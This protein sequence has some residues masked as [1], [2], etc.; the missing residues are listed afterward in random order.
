M[1]AVCVCVCVWMYAKIIDASS[2]CKIRGTNWFVTLAS[3][4]PFTSLN[5]SAYRRS[6]L[7]CFC[8]R[9]GCSRVH[10]SG[11][12]YFSSSRWGIVELKR[13]ECSARSMICSAVLTPL[14]KWMHSTIINSSRSRVNHRQ[15]ECIPLS[16]IYLFQQLNASIN[17]K[18]REMYSFWRS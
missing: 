18:M 6:S 7:F 5:F 17:R 13:Q 15:C 4:L 12:K 9:V 3:L 8:M 16:R 2:S 1:C 14:S 11:C 10:L